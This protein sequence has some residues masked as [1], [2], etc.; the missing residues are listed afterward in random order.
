MNKLIGFLFLLI[1]F[2]SANIVEPRDRLPSVKPVP[3]DVQLIKT[4]ITPDDP[5]QPVIILNTPPKA[6][7]PIL[8]MKYGAVWCLACVR[9]APNWYTKEAKQVLKDKNIGFM[10]IDV[11]KD[12]ESA[13]MWKARTIPCVIMVRLEQNGEATEI[14]R[15][16]GYRSTQEIIQWLKN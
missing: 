16:V 10:E 1:L 9:M 12:P 11:D 6:P 13:T 5:T 15:F 2:V 14:K 3:D 4:V 8:V 7:K